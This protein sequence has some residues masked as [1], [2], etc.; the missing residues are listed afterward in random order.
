MKIKATVKG[1]EI[2]IDIPESRYWIDRNQKR[3]AP[4]WSKADNLEKR[5]N[6]EFEKAYKELEKEL[7]TFAGKLGR[8]KLTYS[9]SRVIALMNELKPHIDNLYDYQQESLTTLLTELYTDNYY[10]GLYDLTIGTKVA[11]YFVGINERAIKAAIT[12]PIFGKN[13]SDAIWQDKTNLIF[14]TRA[15]IKDGLIRGDSIDTMAKQLMYK[16]LNKSTGKITDQGPLGKAKYNARR[17]IQ[18]EVS[19][20]LSIS[21]RDMYKEFGLERFEFVATL[22]DR[23]SQI[24]RG[25]DGKNFP[26][27]DYTPGVNAPVLHAF[28]RSTTVPYFSENTT[29]RMARDLNTGKSVIV[30]DISYNEW[31]NKYVEE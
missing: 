9:E 30:E 5:M 21:D 26:L 29:K 25:L 17:L 6:K 3:M 28:E 12:Y 11:Y 18:T 2:E 22:D 19:Q 24:C 10:K 15:I 16:Q 7:Y 8:E 20:V 31:F 23:T 4:Y 14:N 13:F 27:D 1:K